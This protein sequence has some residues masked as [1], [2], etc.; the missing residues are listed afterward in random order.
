M[1]IVIT[2]STG[3]IG[4]ALV[5]SLEADG[6]TAIRAVRDAPPDQ[7]P[8]LRWSPTAATIDADAFEGVDAVVHLAGAGIA[9]ERWTDD[10]KR[11]IL[12]SRT[13]GTRLLAETLAGLDRPPPVL[14]SGSAVGF[15]G[16]RGDELLTESSTPGAGFLAELCQAWEA[17]TE[18]AEA[19]G[20]R[21]VHARTGLVL[22]DQGGALAEQLPFFKLGLGGRIGDG[23]QYWSWISLRDEVRALRWLID[24]P[25]TGPVN[26]TAPEPARQGDVADEIGRILRRPTIFP[27]PKLALYLRLGR[28]LTQELVLAS[29]RVVPDVLQTSGFDFLDGTVEH[30]LR[31]ALGRR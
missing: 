11:E 8:S 26:L 1:D 17:A 5:E 30:G 16:D 18:P 20:L 31:S 2:G 4:Q 25:V 10:R 6:H 9:D 24:H 12:E 14:V 21:V 28:E 22:S 19:A 13:R 27:T 7:R 29:A 15:Y 23:R 3:L